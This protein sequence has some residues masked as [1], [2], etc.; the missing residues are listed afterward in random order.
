[1]MVMLGPEFDPQKFLA[2][3]DAEQDPSKRLQAIVAVSVASLAILAERA[4]LIKYAAA[5]AMIYHL[6]MMMAVETKKAFALTTLKTA[7][8]LVKMYDPGTKH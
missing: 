4:S 8:D 5:D 3:L 7:T 6:A 2:D 1:M